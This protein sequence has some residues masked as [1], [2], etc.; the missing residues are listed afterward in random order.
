[1]QT[2][3]TD[4]Q[5][6]Y[7]PNPGAGTHQPTTSFFIPNA[8]FTMP[9]RNPAPQYGGPR[10]NQQVIFFHILFYQIS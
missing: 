10:I 5:S 2:M 1:M 3:S 9:G 6:S 8:E 7:Y 4:P